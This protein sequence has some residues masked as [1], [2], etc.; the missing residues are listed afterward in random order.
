MEEGPRALR[1]PVSPKP[2]FREALRGYVISRLEEVGVD[3]ETAR[4]IAARIPSGDDE[5]PNEVING[6]IPSE[7]IPCE[8]I[9]ELI[10]ILVVHRDDVFVDRFEEDAR[11]VRETVLR[12]DPRSF[13]DALLWTVEVRGA[14]AELVRDVLR[15]PDL[16]RAVDL[17]LVVET[18]DAGEAR[19]AT[20]LL[21]LA[22]RE[23]QDPP[24]CRVENSLD[25]GYGVKDLGSRLVRT[26]LA[27]YALSNRMNSTEELAEYLEDLEG[28]RHLE[29][30]ELE[31]SSVVKKLTDAL[32]K[33]IGD[34]IETVGYEVAKELRDAES[35]L[36]PLGIDDLRSYTG[37]I[38]EE[39]KRLTDVVVSTVEEVRDPRR[40]A[41]FLLSADS[42]ITLGDRRLGPDV[43]DP[44]WGAWEH[45]R[46]LFEGDL[47]ELFNVEDVVEE[48]SR[49][50][51]GEDLGQKA[52][53]L[54]VEVTK[55]LIER[56]ESSG[57]ESGGTSAETF[58]EIIESIVKQV[59]ERRK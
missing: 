26:T 14:V 9:E 33:T 23:V 55:R 49:K 32:R 56:S 21:R 15:E 16:A 54:A 53:D 47:S 45:A 57:S 22:G 38:L 52:A 42:E 46:G 10:A 4:R 36:E 11:T 1:I 17:W 37:R 27:A 48:V 25:L 59:F 13:G 24:L 12:E 28:W 5:E 6:L 50:M 7:V 58:Y 19:A 35:A 44:R 51:L 41:R 8:A 40:M 43:Y 39:F 20:E 31:R 30:L 18:L 2:E 3:R 29:K 34:T